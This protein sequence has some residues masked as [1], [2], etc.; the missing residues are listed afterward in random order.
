[1]GPHM[2]RAE[3]TG[4][5]PQQSTGKKKRDGKKERE[6]PR[7][8]PTALYSIKSFCAAHGISEAFYFKLREDGLGPDELRLGARVFITHESAQRWRAE[9]EAA[10][11]AAE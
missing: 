6:E 1:M 4:R 7:A 8:D 10:T 11:T 9:R 2:A 3:V 5:K